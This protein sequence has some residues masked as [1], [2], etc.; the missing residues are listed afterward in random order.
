[1]PIGVARDF[2]MFCSG[3]SLSLEGSSPALRLGLLGS[4][5]STYAA[6]VLKRQSSAGSLRTFRSRSSRCVQCQTHSHLIL[7]CI[8]KISSARLSLASSCRFWLTLPQMSAEVEAKT[9]LLQAVTTTLGLHP[10]GRGSANPSG[11]PVQSSQLAAM[12]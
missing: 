1:M 8:C 7:L 4:T 10:P 11:R 12:D 3:E 9:R 6:S 2:V 5:A